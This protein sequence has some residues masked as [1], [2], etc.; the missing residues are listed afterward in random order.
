[1]GVAEISCQWQR[2][3][4]PEKGG[5]SCSCRTKLA[6]SW[7]ASG[8][9]HQPARRVCMRWGDGVAQGLKRRACHMHSTASTEMRVDAGVVWCVERGGGALA[10]SGPAHLPATARLNRWF[11]RLHVCRN[12]MCICPK[13]SGPRDPTGLCIPDC[14]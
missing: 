14:I 5:G 8:R 4:T 10:R 6:T 7:A 13:S 9:G 12:P 3:G 1:M 11:L 2:Y